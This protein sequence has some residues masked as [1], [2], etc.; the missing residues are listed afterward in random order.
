MLSSS[1]VELVLPWLT[2]LTLLDVT[3]YLLSLRPLMLDE[4]YFLI[5]RARQLQSS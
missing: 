3:R 2:L 5:Q 4:C 1:G